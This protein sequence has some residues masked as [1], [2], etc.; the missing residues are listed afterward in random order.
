MP[1]NAALGALMTAKSH[2]DRLWYITVT[3]PWY[4]D[5][6][7]G[8]YMKASLDTKKSSFTSVLSGIVAVGK[9]T[10]KLGR[11]T[12]LSVDEWIKTGR[13]TMQE[14]QGVC[15]DCAAA[16]ALAFLSADKSGLRVEILSVSTHAFVVVGRAGGEETVKT[17]GEWGEDAFVLD[18]WF[19]NQFGFGRH[20]PCAWMTNRSHPVA[21]WIHG[22]AE[23]LRVE[24]EL[25]QQGALEA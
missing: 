18:I 24:V 12:L 16:A 22:A 3:N 7:E 10:A 5:D 20:A 9:G 21:D 6:P 2:G 8:N 13:N 15:T 11:T 1:S 17:P 14:G 25:R 19:A 23:K 4:V